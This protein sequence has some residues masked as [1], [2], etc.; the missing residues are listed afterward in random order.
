MFAG[1]QGR[2]GL[3]EP[4]GLLRRICAVSGGHREDESGGQGNS[5]DAPAGAW[6]EAAHGGGP[7]HRTRAN[8]GLCNMQIC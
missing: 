6:R 8:S 4:P 5:R 7:Y 1:L 3:A 2:V